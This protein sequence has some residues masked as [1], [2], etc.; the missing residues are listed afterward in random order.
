MSGQAH[1]LVVFEG[2]GRAIVGVSG[3]GL[4]EP[5]AFGVRPAP[6]V[7]AVWRGYRVTY[8]VH[9][10]RLVLQ[11]L[12]IGIDTDDS[13]EAAPKMLFGRELRRSGCGPVVLDDLT[14]PVHF[15]GGML[16]GHEFIQGLEVGGD[17]HPAWRWRA[18]HE[19]LFESGL[20]KAACDRSWQAAEARARLSLRQNEPASARGADL[21]A[22]I[23]KC[24]SLEYGSGA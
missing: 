23:R 17:C 8:A 20:L 22:W 21:D 13:T 4:F 9:S 18:V 2:K 11:R 12:V 3:I 1:D 7:A 16:A 6:W 24:F 14:E 19:L 10:D 5:S 15:T